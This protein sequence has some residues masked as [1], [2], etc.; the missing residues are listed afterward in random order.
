[1]AIVVAIL[2]LVGVFIG[3]RRRI[4][5]DEGPVGIPRPDPPPGVDPLAEIATLQGRLKRAPDDLPSTLLLGSHLIERGRIREAVTLL[6]TAVQRWP[7]EPDVVLRLGRARFELADWEGAIMYADKALELRPDFAD[8]L[9]ARADALAEKL[10]SGPELA[11]EAREALR[12]AIA[13][14]ERRLAAE[15]S[16]TDARAA[17]AVCLFDVGDLEGSRAAWEVAIRQR[18]RDP[19]LHSG[20]AAVLEAQGDE[21]G[22]HSRLRRAAEAQRALA[23]ANPRHPGHA[24]ALAT[25]LEELDEDGAAEARYD[26]AFLDPDD[27]HLH[28]LFVEHGPHHETFLE[29]ARAL[30]TRDW[31]SAR[32]AFLAVLE[33]HPVHLGA[34]AGLALALEELGDTQGAGSAREALR[35]V[36][37]AWRGIEKLRRVRGSGSAG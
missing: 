35:R 11:A 37:P 23:D 7:A 6:L 29:G 31:A 16:D 17:L 30:K 20:L 13:S 9:R 28:E 15:P 36:S 26:A 2:A 32:R 27:S 14:Y 33:E 1:L 21:A 34:Y 5:N 4:E 24:L 18:P 25:L 12:P 19:A 10:W 22:A 8:A 3:L